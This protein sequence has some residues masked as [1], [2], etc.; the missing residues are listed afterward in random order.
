M[1]QVQ[2]TRAAKHHVRQRRL[3]RAL[4]HVR[5]ND[6]VDA[7]VD[8]PQRLNRRPALL[9]MA[10]KHRGL[11]TRSLRR[12]EE[13]SKHELLRLNRVEPHRRIGGAVRE[14]ELVDSLSA[15]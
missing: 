13:L 8:V 1:S 9:E 7:D 15:F 10:A 3:S 2:L 11:E 12:L 4:E 14:V 6:P 5:V